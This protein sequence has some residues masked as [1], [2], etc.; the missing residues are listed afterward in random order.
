MDVTKNYINGNIKKTLDSHNLC[1][2]QK[3]WWHKGLSLLDVATLPDELC[4][5]TAQVVWDRVFR[6]REKA[7]QLGNW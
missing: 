6:G 7:E 3:A 2:R 1:Q 5:K 4:I